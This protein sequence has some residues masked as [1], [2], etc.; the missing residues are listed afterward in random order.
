[1]ARSK[2]KTKPRTAK[3]QRSAKAARHPRSYTPVSDALS[4]PF[5]FADTEVAE[6]MRRHGLSG[7][8]AA[9]IGGR[10]RPEAEPLPQLLCALLTWPLLKVRSLHC[11]CAELCQILAGKVSV[12]YDF[13]G[14]EDIN[15][16][17]V[18]AEL[19][20]Q[21]YRNRPATPSYAEG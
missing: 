14:R 4:Q 10:R 19:S 3:S 12:L 2:T 8:L 21:V 1:M 13:L 18:D 11:F 7:L 6:G 17:G 5:T 15:W 9:A 16:R 20:R